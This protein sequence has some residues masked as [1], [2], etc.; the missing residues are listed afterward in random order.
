MQLVVANAFGRAGFLVG[1]AN[2]Q[3]R[4]VH[5][6]RAFLLKQ[7]GHVIGDPVKFLSADDKIE[8]G[9]L[10]EE[11]ITARLGHATEK[12]KNGLGPTPRDLAEHAHFPER[13]LFGHIPD[14][15]CV[16]KD[17]IRIRFAGGAL[18]AAFQERVRDLFR[19]ALV[20]LAAVGFDEKFRHP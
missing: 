20:H 8:M 9:H 6:A 14:A 5:S 3:S 13:F 12:A 15:A 16:Q 4:V 18:I 11:C 7:L 17:D 2:R 10:A 19:V 1:I